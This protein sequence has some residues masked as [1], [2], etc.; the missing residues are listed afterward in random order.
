M[1][2]L[3]VPDARLLAP[4]SSS[5]RPSHPVLI[6][7]VA[8]AGSVSGYSGGTAADFHRVP[9]AAETLS[10]M[11]NQDVADYDSR[12]KRGTPSFERIS[13]TVSPS[14]RLE[15]KNHRTVLGIRER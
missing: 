10:V 11:L 1:V 12:V 9:L 15:A 4:G 7:A 6:Q 5:A 2:F 14:D 8:L 3:R 13:E